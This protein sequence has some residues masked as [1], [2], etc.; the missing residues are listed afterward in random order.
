MLQVIWIHGV[1][2]E[3]DLSNEKLSPEFRVESGILF[4]FTDFSDMR[5]INLNGYSSA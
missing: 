2:K 5:G 1:W 4:N 3:K